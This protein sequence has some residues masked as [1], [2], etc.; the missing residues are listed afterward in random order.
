LALDELI[1]L[2]P[3]GIVTTSFFINRI[4]LDKS[5]SVYILY[6]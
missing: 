4:L 1:P 5:A 2:T 3:V 6:T